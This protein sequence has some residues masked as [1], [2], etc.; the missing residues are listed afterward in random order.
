MNNE[1]TAFSPAKINLFFEAVSKLD[2]GYHS[3]E[4]I[5]AKLA[6]GDDIK[7]SAAPA[8]ATTIAV[9]A[10]GPFGKYIKEDKTNLVYKAA[11]AFFDFFNIKAACQIRIEKNLPIAAGL[12][13]GSSDAAA[14]I[15]ALCKL[16]SIETNAKRMKDLIKLSAKLGA[17]VPVFLQPETFYKAQGIG[18]VLTPLKARIKSPYIVL[19][20]PGVPSSTKDAYA[21][22]KLN[23]PQ[24]VS[25]NVKA[26]EKILQSIQAGAPLQ[27]W[28]GLMYNKLE[29]AVLPR[30]NAVKDLKQKMTALGAQYALMSGSGSCVFALVE[31]ESL[32][33][34]IAAALTNDGCAV[35][36]THF[37]GLKPA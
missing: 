1:I 3:I 22:L 10:R 28:G 31:D 17:D 36:V 5:F 27:D 9:K 6:V 35:F 34:K 7:I 13:G 29:D 30:I 14:V 23:N 19:A 32:A 20:H 37:W 12:G 4:T 25:T 11:Q 33:Q 24:Q 21:N 15:L 18:E 8:A 26:M 16:F 2:N